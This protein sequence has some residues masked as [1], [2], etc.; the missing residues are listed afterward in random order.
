MKRLLF[1][2]TLVISL[3]GNRLDC[4]STASGSQTVNEKELSGVVKGKVV[5]AGTGEGVAYATV[6]VVDLD[7]TVVAA[8]YSSESGEFEIKVPQ[9]G[10]YE[11]RIALIG[12][13]DGALRF[14]VGGESTESA[15]ENA[16]SVKESAVINKV[17]A[18]EASGSV[19]VGAVSLEPDTRLLEA[20]KVTER[21]PLV[22]VKIDKVVVNVSQSAFA[23]TSTALDMLRKSPG[24]TV[25]KDGNVKLN[26]KSV[27]VWI[28]GRPSHLDGK[29]LESLLKATQG[30]NLDKIEIMEHPS[31]KYDAEGQGGI[32]NIKTKKN[33]LDGLQGSVNASGGGMYYSGLDLWTSQANAGLNLSY[34]TAKTNTFLN[35]NG[36]TFNAFQLETIETT[37]RLD[38]P[39]YSQLSETMLKFGSNYTN[40]R[41]GNDW[42]IDSKNTL[43]F[44]VSFPASTNDVM[45]VPGISKATE[46]VAGK[47]THYETDLLSPSGDRQSSY[48]LNFTHIFDAAKAEEITVN[49]DYYHN[50]SSNRSRTANWIPA[51][52]D[53]IA[54]RDIVSS[55][56]L[57]IWSVKADYQRV[58]FGMAMMEAGAKWSRS[59][60]STG[61]DRSEM[62]LQPIGSTFKYIENIGAVYADIAAQLGPKFSAKAGLRGE[63]TSS[64][65]KSSDYPDKNRSY[66][67]LFPTVFV[68]YNPSQNLSLSASYTRRINR[69][70]Y[71]QLDPVAMYTDARNC[72]VGNPDL[73]PE[74]DNN[75]MLSAT[76]KQHFSFSIGY[77]H[78]QDLQS[79]VPSIDANG[80]T[81]LIWDNFGDSYMGYAAF[82]VSALPLTK[83]M[84]WT[85]SAYGMYSHSE[86]YDGTVIAKPFLNGYTS[87]T[88]MLPKD[89]KIEVDA[90][91]YTGMNWGYFIMEPTFSS[92]LGVRKTLLDGKMTLSFDVSDLFRT[93]NTDLNMKVEGFEKAFIGQKQYMQM[94]K[95]GL[96]WNFGKSSHPTRTR[97][98]GNLEEA[99]RA[100]GSSSIG[101]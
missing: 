81:A 46:T 1:L 4:Y 33:A 19:N 40:I 10:E 50:V 34:R 6:A 97:K 66:F 23:Q 79:Q 84:I 77:S 44:I 76:Y 74:Y 15:K 12:Y 39:T 101:K 16:E 69:P 27:A 26:G 37:D 9:A 32:I 96:S 56:G 67:K 28:D 61:M 5:E 18:A 72:I 36:G 55:S 60:T 30:S 71:G 2:V 22:E 43:G 51:T 98:V 25:D 64:V 17:N 85:L 92:N 82:N 100:G 52:K 53:T 87:L 29:S 49:A 54:T 59:A 99:A 57:D 58:V 80:N 70:R 35:A 94:A 20:A 47:T 89:W 78:T 48:N 41:F 75:V 63:Y 13:K 21:I 38:S 86:S 8:G 90:Y 83:W 42:F 11:L 45:S 65:G 93:T 31:A 14:R 24:V 91:G 73:Q 3:C 95:L 7:S 88:F 68:G 62:G